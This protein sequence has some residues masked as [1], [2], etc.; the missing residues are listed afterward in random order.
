MKYHEECL[1]CGHTYKAYT[2]SLNVQMLEAFTIFV[3][4]YGKEK[5]PLPVG[6]DWGLT[7]SQYTNFYKLQYYNLILKVEGGYLPTKRGLLFIRGEYAIRLPVVVFKK[8]V[9]PESHEA[10][11][12]VRE[13][14]KEKYIWDIDD[15]YFKN[16]QDYA[17][18][19]SKQTSLL[20]T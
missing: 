15:R 5:K 19:A 12:G 7:H 10:W 1:H 20:N 2:E 17:E 13:K 18:E 3:K 4:H 9:L 16:R 8:K 11:N 6:K 14:V